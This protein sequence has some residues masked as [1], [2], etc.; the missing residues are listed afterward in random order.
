[1]PLLLLKLTLTPLLVGG[2][3]LAARRWGPAVGGWL[4]S[5][6][7]T[8]GP[9]LF[10]LAV[11]NG[12][13]FAA[14]VAVGTLLGLGA[15]V[16]YCLGYVAASSRGPWIAIATASVAYAAAGLVAAGLLAGLPFALL[17][18]LVVAAIAG[19]LRVIPPPGSTRNG[20]PHPAWDLPVRIVVGT[21]LVLGLTAI[22]PL[23]GPI[24]SGIVATFPV[25]VSVLAVF[26][27]LRDGPRAA[28]DVLRGLL[29]G[30]FGTAAFFVVL[31]V[32]LEPYGIAVA[33]T[34]AV[35]VTLAIAT[36]ALRVVR[37]GIAASA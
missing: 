36:V 14:D 37:A 33:F 10:F 6:P 20:A 29:T 30:L 24:F 1:V 23:L 7:L 27:Q 31:H 12:P 15:I 8:S 32:L 13:A 22:A 21:G 18:V 4:V 11:E 34:L 5:L 2:A 16:A 19:A 26:T 17:V 9:I 28:T 3:S 25:Y 35:A